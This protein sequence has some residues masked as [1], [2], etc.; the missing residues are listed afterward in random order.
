MDLNLSIYSFKLSTRA[1]NVTIRENIFTIQDLINK[2][3]YLWTLKWVWDNL[4]DEFNGILF[5]FIEDNIDEFEWID[6]LERP[7]DMYDL[8][9]RASTVALKSWYYKCYDLIKNEKIIW[10]L[11]WA[12]PKVQ[13]EL[14]KIINKIKMEVVDKFVANYKWDMIDNN[15]NNKYI[16]SDYSDPTYYIPMKR[17]KS[18]VKKWNLN[19]HDE[20]KTPINDYLYEIYNSEKDFDLNEFL[21]IYLNT[22]TNIEYAVIE[23]IIWF[24]WNNELK[25]YCDLAREYEITWERVRQIEKSIKDRIKQLIF[26][27]KNTL[28]W[29]NFLQSVYDALNNCDYKILDFHD[30]SSEKINWKFLSFVH[31]NFYTDEYDSINISLSR[32]TSEILLVFKN[33]IFD[34][35]VIHKLFD[36]VDKLYN[37]KRPEEICY[38]KDLLLSKI[39]DRKII[40][41]VYWNK[42]YEEILIEYLACVYYIFEFN[43]SFTFPANKKDLKYLVNKEL[44][45]L[46]EPIHF[47]DMY[48]IVIEKYPEQNWNPAKVHSALNSLGKNVGDWLYVK[49]S[50]KMIEWTIAWLTEIFLEKYWKPA[51][52]SEIEKFILE[53]RRV[54]KESLLTMI[55][56][57]KKKRFVKTADHK[58]WL[59]KWDLP[60]VVDDRRV[61]YTLD[62]EIYNYMKKD[63]L[64]EYTIQNIMDWI[65]DTNYQNVYYAVTNLVKDWK[66]GYFTRWITNYY[67]VM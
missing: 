30:K 34:K 63:P 21:D 23:N 18:W 1:Y 28:L 27:F 57:D 36:N 29:K 26:D 39:T 5:E 52:Y 32:D 65:W 19:K 38:S 13:E 10:N 17:V 6:T 16:I 43:N 8:S 45:L 33:K 59:K 15:I 58:I 46:D 53:N 37:D 64:E 67:Y 54:K 14:H 2:R 31:S 62:N 49:K 25:K 35:K 51:P 4:I 56:L 7:I 50:S 66:I 22:L 61:S 60:N 9:T 41:T 20:R 55:F 24:T 42:W 12:W 48:N 40:W 11:E 44:E 3:S 47:T